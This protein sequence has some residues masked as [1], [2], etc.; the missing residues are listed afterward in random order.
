MVVTKQNTTCRTISKLGKIKARLDL[1]T[2][3]LLSSVTG[4]YLLT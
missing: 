4:F 2:N 1:R 3:F